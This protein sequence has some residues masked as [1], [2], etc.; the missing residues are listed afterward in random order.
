MTLP[1]C[2]RKHIKVPIRFLLILAFIYLILCPFAQTVTPGD[3]SQ[4][5][6]PQNQ[7]VKYHVTQKDYFF[8]S[9]H[10]SSEHRIETWY[11]GKD[12]RVVPCIIYQKPF[13]SLLTI[14]TNR[15]II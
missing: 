14:T 4:A 8:S 2:Q 1:L 15:L 9:A 5:L 12:A 10:I 13:F 6:I 3:G 7:S 11:Y